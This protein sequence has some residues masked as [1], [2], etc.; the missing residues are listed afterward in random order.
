[1]RYPPDHKARTRERILRAAA[2]VFRRQGYHAAGIDQVMAAAG[3]TAGAFYNHFPSKEALLAEVLPYL[4]SQ[5][6]GILPE[7]ESPSGERVW[8]FA[9]IESYLSALHRDHPERGCAVPA[10]VSE[11]PR[12]GEAPRTAFQDLLR[13]LQDRLADDLGGSNPEDLA[14]EQ[15]LV[16]LALC[17]GGITLSRAVPDVDLRE[18][19]LAACRKHALQLLPA[20]GPGE[21]EDPVL[22][23]SDG[24]ATSEVTS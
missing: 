12:S 6:L 14:K 2:D 24:G 4:L 5:K 21:R 10:V 19:V 18:E 16:L 8:A 9:F 20:D 15:A 13:A 17:V 22:S 3:L 7:P 1:M 11:L 23:S